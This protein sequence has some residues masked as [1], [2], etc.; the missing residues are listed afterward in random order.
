MGTP[1]TVGMLVDAGADVHRLNN[2]GQSPAESVIAEDGGPVLA[3]L[4][5]R[6]V[7]PRDPK[8][9]CCA[10]LWGKTECLRVLLR[11]GADPNAHV[12]PAASLGFEGKAVSPS[13]IVCA[14]G[15]AAA[16]DVLKEFGAR[17]SPSDERILATSLTLRS[18]IFPV[19]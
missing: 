10:A 18:G 5:R 19:K 14:G 3:E 13:R 11:A 16:I 17:V 4:L 15:H 1:E 2:R 7:D 12:E 9:M 6:G 8:L